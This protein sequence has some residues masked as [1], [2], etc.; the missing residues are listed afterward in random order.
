MIIKSNIHDYSLEFG[1]YLKFL[2]SQVASE[3]IIIID[4]T[5]LSLYDFPKDLKIISIKSE[6]F[7]KDFFE[8]GHTIKKIIGFDFKKNNKIFAVGGGVIQD[9]A[10]F[11]SSILFRGV[12]W[13]FLPTT[14]LS[15]SDSCIGGKT[16]VN[17]GNVKNQIGGYYPPKKICIDTSFL[18]SLPKSQILSGLGEMLHYYIF[19]S[20]ESFQIFNFLSDSEDYETLIKKSLGIK[21]SVIESDEKEKGVR[22]LFN[23]GHTFGHAL[24]TIS[25]YSIPHGVAVSIGMDISNYISYQMNFLPESK[26]MEMKKTLK[27]IYGETKMDTI[28]VENFFEILKKDKKNIPNKICP[29]LINDFGNLFQHE[30]TY[31][32][33]LL[34]FLKNYFTNE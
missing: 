12:D 29:I 6:E 13:Y 22:I 5:I 25:S 21:K 3:D 2:N 19:D 9:I 16:S 34:I 8:I 4:K 27:K 17:F 7:S 28:N 26:Y 14:L 11:I 1:D 24:E 32:D 18:K 10:G 31:T 23:Y 33:N 30:F 20:Y 15:Q